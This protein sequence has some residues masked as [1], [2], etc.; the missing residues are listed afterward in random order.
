[1]TV[2]PPPFA[3]AASPIARLDDKREF[4]AAQKAQKKA[5]EEAARAELRRGYQDA[6]HGKKCEK[7]LARQRAR[8]QA[9][10]ADRVETR[11]VV[12]DQRVE[13]A[14]GARS[15]HRRSYVEGVAHEG[16]RRRLAGGGGR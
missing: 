3:G 1:M 11:R 12:R 13:A 8:A 14:A 5:E 16:R 6:M 9:E 15:A 4:Y 7:N 2:E 10:V